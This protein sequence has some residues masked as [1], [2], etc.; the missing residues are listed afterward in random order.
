MDYYWEILGYNL[1]EDCYI[2]IAKYCFKVVN[3]L[4]HM[5]MPFYPTLWVLKIGWQ[6]SDN[7]HKSEHFF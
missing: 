5:S 2:Y 1:L 6:K 7:C 3:I 4:I